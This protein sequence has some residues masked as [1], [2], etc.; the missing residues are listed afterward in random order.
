VFTSQIT[1][2]T[3]IG[4]CLI[5]VAHTSVIYATLALLT[6]GGAGIGGNLLTA[7]MSLG[8]LLRRGRGGLLLTAALSM[9]ESLRHSPADTAGPVEDV[10]TTVH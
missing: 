3:Y 10:R 6:Y 1:A 2:Q 9:R 7:K 8:R 4:A 5:G